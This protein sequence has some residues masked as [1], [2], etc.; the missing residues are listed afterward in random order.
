M[1][2][3]EQLIERGIKATHTIGIDGESDE[4]LDSNAE[5]IVTTLIDA[6]LPLV[7]DP[8]ELQALPF[9]TILISPEGYAIQVYNVTLGTRSQR[10]YRFHSGGWQAS[11]KSV[12]LTYGPLMVVWQP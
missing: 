6:L 11:A 3:R 4:I 2:T 10:G 12:M 1:S 7:T 5:E 8:E 9:G